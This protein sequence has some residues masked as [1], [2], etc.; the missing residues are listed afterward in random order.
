M[1]YLVSME[2]SFLSIYLSSFFSNTLGIIVY[3]PLFLTLIEISSFG[4]FFVFGYYMG[5]FKSCGSLL[6]SVGITFFYFISIS[7]GLVII[8]TFFIAS[9]FFKDFF[10]DELFALFFLCF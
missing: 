9:A 3:E 4:C 1:G 5:L 8:F 10:F 2:S 7:T 6:S